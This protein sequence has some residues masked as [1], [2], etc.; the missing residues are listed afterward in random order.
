MIRKLRY[1]AF[2]ALL[3]YFFDPQNGRRRRALAR[4]R[5]PA[6]LPQ[7]STKAGDV[8]QCRTVRGLRRQAEGDAPQGRREAS[9]RRRHARTQGRDRDLPRLGHPEGSDQRQRREREGRPARRGRAARAD[10]G[11]RAADE[12]GP[13]RP[14]GREPAPRARRGARRSSSAAC[15]TAQGNEPAGRAVLPCSHRPACADVRT[16]STSTEGAPC[17]SSRPSPQS[18]G[19]LPKPSRGS[20]R[21]RSRWASPTTTTRRRT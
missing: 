20:R 5:I 17:A 16:S 13:G 2:G 6:V 14:G 9:A 11:P 3:A 10:Q 4:Q 8:G 1:M 15:G 7:G 18:P 21:S 12:E 19:S